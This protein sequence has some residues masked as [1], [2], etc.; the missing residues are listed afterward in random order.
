MLQKKTPTKNTKITTKKKPQQKNIKK[1]PKKK[2]KIRKAAEQM[3][4]I[5]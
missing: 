3:S 2:K 4:E 5:I 1:I